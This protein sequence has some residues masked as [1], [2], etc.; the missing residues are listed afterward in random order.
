M[1][2]LAEQKTVLLLL[3][4]VTLAS[5]FIH[6]LRAQ[7][8]ENI[9]LFD[10]HSGTT[11]KNKKLLWKALLE[12]KP[13]VII[14]V[15]LPVLLPIANLG[16]IVVDEEHETGYQEKKHPKINSKEAAIWR[17]HLDNVPILLGSATPS[18]T[19]LYNVKKKGMVLFPT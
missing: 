6:L 18:V 16:L 7:L 15:H 11:P 5:Q 4:E 13:I 10:F 9:Q 12:Q 2:T 3:P 19:S 8:P 17:A 1:H 14:G